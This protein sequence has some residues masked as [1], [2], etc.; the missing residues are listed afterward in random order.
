MSRDTTYLRHIREALVRAISHARHGRE[1]FLLDRDTQDAAIRNLEVAGEAAKRVSA[2][3]RHSH[4]EVPWGTLARL[5]DVLIH[6]YMNVDIA[7]IWDDLTLHVPSVID[8]V[9]RILAEIQEGGPD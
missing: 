4:P 9:D 8:S 7:A 3:L 1:R 5:R 6:Q 2:S